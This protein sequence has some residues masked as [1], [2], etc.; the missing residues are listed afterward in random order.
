MC[1]E[2]MCITDKDLP[3]TILLK[4][5]PSLWKQKDILILLIGLDSC[6]FGS[7]YLDANEKKE[8]SKL[9]TNYF[10]ERY[11]VSRTVL[12]FALH[13]LLGGQAVFKIS[14]Y[15]DEYG[16]VHVRDHDELHICFSYTG[17]IVSLAISKVDVGMDIELIKPFS[18]GK[19][20]KYLNKQALK[21]DGLDNCPDLLTLFTLKEAYSKFS[22]ESI[23]SCINKELDLSSI[24]SSSYILNNSY[25]LSIINDMKPLAIN[26]SYLQKI[27][28]SDLES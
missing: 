20:S 13:Y 22:N 2:R 14:T 7:E 6:I 15:K 17:K 5:V 27:E 8:L 1:C 25:I 12:K 4:D 11:V 24:Y 18:T 23:I 28:A 3:S 10:R 9:K 19:F 21:T 16:R 26:I